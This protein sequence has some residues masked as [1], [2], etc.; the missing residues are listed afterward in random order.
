MIRMIRMI[1]KRE[2]EMV[3]DAKR[4]KDGENQNTEFKREYTEEIKKTIIAF[5]NTSGGILF[6]GVND[7][8]S[9]TG[10]DT[11]DDTLLQVTNV[12]RAAI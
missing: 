4:I 2:K 9:I 10:I 11:P 5:A 3:L 12:I 8:K 1:R 7:D 6:I